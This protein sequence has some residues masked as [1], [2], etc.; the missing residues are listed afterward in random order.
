MSEI[1]YYKIHNEQDIHIEENLQSKGENVGQND[2][3]D[4]TMSLLPT[5]LSV[6]YPDNNKIQLSYDD[7]FK[8]MPNTP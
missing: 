2:T 4:D 5:S 7:S 1:S 6:V 3:V 8:F